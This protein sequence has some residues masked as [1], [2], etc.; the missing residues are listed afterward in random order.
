MAQRAKRGLGDNENIRI[1]ETNPRSPLQ[2]AK[3]E[4]RS[5][6]SEG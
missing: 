2:S 4:V 1:E 5:Q 6:K 3:A